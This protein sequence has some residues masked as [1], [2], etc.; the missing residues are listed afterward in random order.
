[1]SA[2]QWKRARVARGQIGAGPALGGADDLWYPPH[3]A[4]RPR[5]RHLWSAWRSRALGPDLVLPG[6]SISVEIARSLLSS[7]D[8]IP[9]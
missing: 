4:R 6:A 2:R 5:A 8:G 3:P 7:D 1:M 9:F